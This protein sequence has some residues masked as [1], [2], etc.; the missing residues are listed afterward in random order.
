MRVLVAYDGTLQSKDALR[1]GIDKVREKGGDLVA[2]HVFDSGM[3]VDYD[4]LPGAVEVAKRQ[5]AKFV[6]EA[7]AI[8]KESGTGIRSSVF[9]SEGDP[10]ETII[11]FARTKNVDVLLCSPKYKSI[12]RKYKKVLSR[13]GKESG[14]SAVFDE[15]ERLKIAA[16]S[17][18]AA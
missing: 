1:Y 3:F 5:S 12:I 11:D 14:E 7:K 10:E 15:A 9:V 17:V 18:K 2:L 8:I 6:E 16:V 13:Q 4:A